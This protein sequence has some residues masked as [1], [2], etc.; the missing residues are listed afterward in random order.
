MMGDRIIRAVIRAD[1]DKAGRGICPDCYPEG[2]PWHDA[3]RCATCSGTGRVTFCSSCGAHRYGIIPAHR[4]LCVGHQVFG[5]SAIW[6][7]GP[8]AHA[9]LEGAGIKCHGDITAA[10]IV[11][12]K[13][14]MG[15][16]TWQR[17]PC[18]TKF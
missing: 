9:A 18:R 13:R 12:A 8:A 11:V 7:D 2:H 6:H 10:R 16:K 17:L 15:A 1:E 3:Q 5:P 4:T 14:L